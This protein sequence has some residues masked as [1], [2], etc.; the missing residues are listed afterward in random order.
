MARISRIVI[1]GVPH[2]VTQRGNRKEKIFFEDGDHARYLA[3][4]KEGAEKSGT[5]IWAYCLM[6][7][8]VH[9]I[10]VPTHA[11]GLRALFAEAHRRYTNYINWRHGWTG[12]L[13]QGR[14]GSVAMDEDHLAEAVRYVLLNPVRAGLVKSARDWPHS[15]I[16]AH[17]GGKPNAL[18]DTAPLASR[19]GDFSGLLETSGADD[20][21]GFRKSETTGRPLGSLDWLKSIEKSTGRRLTSA[22]RGPKPRQ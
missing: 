16:L 17:I 1:P 3:F 11:D 15:S 5:S 20:F 13:W 7:N 6:P 12:H 9:F 19:F 21:D 22:K 4:L 2:H 10:A 18:L 14:F 8:H